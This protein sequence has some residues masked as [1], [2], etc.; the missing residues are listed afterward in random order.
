MVSHLSDWLWAGRRVWYLKL[1]VSYPKRGHSHGVKWQKCEADH[2]HPSRA[3]VYTVWCFT[4][5]LLIHL[6]GCRHRHK[7]FQYLIPVWVF[8]YVQTIPLFKEALSIH[9]TLLELWTLWLLYACFYRGTEW[10]H[11]ALAWVQ[12]WAPMNVTEWLWAFQG[13][14][15]M[16]FLMKHP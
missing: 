14:C 1:A 3:E 12:W 8:Y 11:L 7:C 10:I 6:H 5:M 15:S 16:G 4:N 9:G 2:P 13:H